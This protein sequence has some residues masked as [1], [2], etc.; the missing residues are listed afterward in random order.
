MGCAGVGRVAALGIVRAA[1]LDE[2]IA[3]IN[4]NPR[5]N[6]TALFTGDGA[7][8]RRFQQDVEVGMVGIN[9]AIPVPMAY[10]SFGGWR[11]SLYGDLHVHGMDGF[12]FYTRQKVVTTRWPEPAGGGP[13]LSFPTNE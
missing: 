8:A 3:L 13:G 9:V 11:R 2:A 4:A 10:Y 12:R 1:S 5:A 7:A 6:G